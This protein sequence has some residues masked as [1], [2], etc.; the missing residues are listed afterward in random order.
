MFSEIVPKTIGAMHWQRLA[1]F[2]V[3]SLRVLILLLAPLVWMS[4]Y[5]TRSLKRDS[6]Q[7]ILTRTDFL[8]M[9]EL[10]PR[11]ACSKKRKEI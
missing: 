9:A 8:A 3:H 6:S 5:I 2:T 11:K 7:P 1:R 10:A 4:Q